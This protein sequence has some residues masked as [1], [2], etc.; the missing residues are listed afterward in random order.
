MPDE[1][2]LA[3]LLQDREL[4]AYLDPGLGADKRTL[5]ASDVASTILHSYGNALRACP[6]LCRPAAFD[7]ATLVQRGL[8]GFF[9]GSQKFQK[10]RFLHPEEAALLL[11]LPS[12]INHH[13]DVRAALSLLGLA[14]SPIQMVWVYSHLKENVQRALQLTPLPA[15]DY[16]LEQYC[17]G[18]LRQVQPPGLL[19]TQDAAG[20]ELSCQRAAG[21]TTL[22]L[23]QAQ[24][25][26]MH[27]NESSSVLHQ[28][29]RL[30]L[31]HLLPAASTVQLELQQGPTTRPQPHQAVIILVHHQDQAHVLLATAGQ[32]LFELLTPMSLESTSWWM[33]MARCMEPITECGNH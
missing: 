5:E 10:P 23:L 8:R 3:L 29:V 21:S 14:A 28:E 18:L 30:P 13:E 26:T 11:G 22:H 7:R 1:D 6:C 25:L 12:T 16:W 4:A 32:F 17:M 15:P 9:V 31:D 24:R 20:G 33:I 2:E 19:H 27:W